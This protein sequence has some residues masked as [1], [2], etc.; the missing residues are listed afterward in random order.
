M[1]WGVPGEVAP[2]GGAGTGGVVV[3]HVATGGVGGRRRQTGWDAGTLVLV[4][5]VESL[6]LVLEPQG[7]VDL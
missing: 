1:S 4:D 3:G 5:Q 6:A 7:F 2:P